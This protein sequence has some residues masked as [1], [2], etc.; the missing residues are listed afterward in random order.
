MV[1]TYQNIMYVP[2]LCKADIS[3]NILVVICTF[4]FISGKNMDCLYL[5]ELPLTYSFN[6]HTQSTLP[7]FDQN[8]DVI[9]YKGH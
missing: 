8:Y 3:N 1:C 2:S 7:G 5:S 6:E 4:V 9:L